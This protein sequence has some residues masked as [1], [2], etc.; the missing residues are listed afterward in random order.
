M[1]L[2]LDQQREGLARSVL[3]TAQPVVLLPRP[4]AALPP[5]SPGW[6]VGLGTT[7]TAAPPDLRTG[8]QPESRADGV[9]KPLPY[10]CHGEVVQGFGRGSKQLGIPTANFPEQV[11]DNLPADVS[12]GIY[13]RWAS[14]G[15]G[16]VHK[17]V[18]SIGWNPCYKNMK[19]SMETHVIRAFKED[20]YGEILNVAIAGHLGPEKNLDSLESLISAI[21]GDIEEAKK[22]LDLP[23]HLKLKEDNFFQVPKSKIMNGH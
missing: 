18:V 9:M 20:C 15:T 5:A 17:M 12:T 10:F 22:R 2:L 3:S 8:P 4:P 11:V 21:Q 23:E 14:V 19:K 13:Y 1:Q 16:E 7:S 6:S